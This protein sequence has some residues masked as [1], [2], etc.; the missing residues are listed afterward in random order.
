[1]RLEIQS[2]GV[3]FV[4]ATRIAA[5]L[6]LGERVASGLIA[7][8]GLRLANQG[9]PVAW[10]PAPAGS[11]LYFYGEELS[12]MYASENVYWLALGR[13]VRMSSVAGA[14]TLEGPGFHVQSEHLE[15]DVFAALASTDR[16][17]LQYWSSLMASSAYRT[18]T[19][20]S[21]ELRRRRVSTMATVVVHAGAT[22][23]SAG[24]VNG[25][26][27]GGTFSGAVSTTLR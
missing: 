27:P 16:L 24:R 18:G 8:G 17:R 7:L 5:E 14:P 12:T 23:P 4:S 19:T 2:T 13:G 9:V 26:R 1:M 22:T 21:G 10:H 20:G 25:T 11:G 15:Q 3:Y 6:G